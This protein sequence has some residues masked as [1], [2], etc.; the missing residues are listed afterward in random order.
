MRLLQN[1]NDISNKRSAAAGVGP[2]TS[3]QRENY[4]RRW[5]TYDVSN[6]M[7][8]VRKHQQND[9]QQVRGN[10]KKKWSD[11]YSVGEGKKTRDMKNGGG[12]GGGGGRGKGSPI[13]S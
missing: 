12:G 5:K 9:I 1:I 3:Q 10:M 2:F 8:S 4:Y 7:N 13:R 6:L 11:L